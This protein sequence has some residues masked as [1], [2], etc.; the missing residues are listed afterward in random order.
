VLD[1]NGFDV[2]SDYSASAKLS[3][4]G[5]YSLQKFTRSGPGLFGALLGGNSLPSD[6]GGFAG[7]SNVRNDSIAGGLNYTFS[8]TLTTD[9][10]FGYLRYHVRVLPGGF[11][12]SPATDAGI[13]G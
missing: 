4:F 6:L 2:R 11:G 1:S 7:T 10:R 13:P 12:T 9:F 3:I 8:P 5:R